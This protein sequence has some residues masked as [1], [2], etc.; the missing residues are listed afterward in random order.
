M[1]EIDSNDSGKIDPRVV[2]EL[3]SLQ[4]PGGPNVF[5]ELVAMF[6]VEMPD[7]L[8]GIRRAMDSQDAT[9]LTNEAHRL[10]GSSQQMGATRLSLLCCRMEELGRSNKL[11]DATLLI[12]TEREAALVRSALEALAF[13]N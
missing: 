3:R 5:A 4:Q 9:A 2:G 10:K 8:A 13:G 11:V 6:I 1:S 7:R 12:E